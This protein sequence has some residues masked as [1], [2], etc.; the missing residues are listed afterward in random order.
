MTNVIRTRISDVLNNP[1]FKNELLEAKNQ[2]ETLIKKALTE[3]RN[4]QN[5]P[6]ISRI[7]NPDRLLAKIEQ[8]DYDVTTWRITEKSSDDEIKESIFQHINDLIGFRVLCTFWDEEEEVGRLLNSCFGKEE[9]TYKEI[10]K[11]IS[12]WKDD[13]LK[14]QNDGTKNT[15]YK[16]QGLYKNVPFEIQVKCHMHNV[17]GEVDH[18]IVYKQKRYKG[19][20]GLIEELVEQIHASLF[21]VD[22]E[23]EKIFKEEKTQNQTLVEVLYSL[24]HEDVE[25]ECGSVFTYDAYFAFQKIFL[26]DEDQKEAENRNKALREYIGYRL[27]GTKESYTKKELSLSNYDEARVR[28]FDRL[29]ANTQKIAMKKL[30]DELFIIKMPTNLKT[31]DDWDK[32]MALVLVKLGLIDEKEED[33]IYVEEETQEQPTDES[34]TLWEP[35]FRQYKLRKKK[36]VQWNSK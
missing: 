14:T 3:K 28:N 17:W 13:T 31:V 12:E 5:L 16:Y 1:Q 34:S 25:K 15:I 11:D 30:F 33:P 8:N 36:N 18:E 6:I 29:L 20:Q 10:Y 32:F 26:A 27:L 23:L 4:F 24:T 35:L 7:K 19:E 21:A 9:D 2:L 22:K